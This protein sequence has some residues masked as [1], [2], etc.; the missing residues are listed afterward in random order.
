M[1]KRALRSDALLKYAGSLLAI[2]LRFVYFTS[3][4]VFET[5]DFHDRIRN[6]WPII[7]AIWHGQELMTPFMAPKDKV[8]HILISKHR[9]GELASH[10]ITG[11]GLRVIRGSGSIGKQVLRK[12]GASALRD[13]L[14][15]LENGDSVA[16]TADVPKIARQV[17]RGII[18]VA[19][20][21][22]RPIYPLAAVTSRRFTF[23]KTWDRG[24]LPLPFSR[25]AISLG[26]PLHVPAEASESELET[27]RLA[28]QQKMEKVTAQ[29]YALADKGAKQA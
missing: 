24:F 20:I 3:R 23:R 9:D 2:Y 12:G 22:G 13:M 18:I 26:E 21:S 6:G 27:L 15:A 28:L 7:V 29:A 4:T 11:L 5:H 17:G 14:R 10:I 16:L 19:Q 25:L 1:L 8:I